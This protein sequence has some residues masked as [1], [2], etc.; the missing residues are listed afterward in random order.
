MVCYLVQCIYKNLLFVLT[1]CEICKSNLDKCILSARTF[2]SKRKALKLRM[3]WT[4]RCRKFA[5]LYFLEK[6]MA[7]EGGR[8]VHVE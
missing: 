4:N 2:T 3:I 8:V 1:Y 7:M 6:V 5:L